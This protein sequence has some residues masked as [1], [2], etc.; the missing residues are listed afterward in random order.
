MQHKQAQPLAAWL[1][2]T[3]K[4]CCLDEEGWQNDATATFNTCD[5]SRHAICLLL[6]DSAMAG[7][8]YCWTKAQ[9]SGGCFGIR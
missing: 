2:E 3:C 9:G 5:G 7:E 8:S 4:G 1:S 6:E